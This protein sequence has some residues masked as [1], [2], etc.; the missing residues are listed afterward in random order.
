VRPRRRR[1]VRITLYTRS[2]CGLC[3]QAEALVAREAGGAEV[4]LVD[5]DVD[6]DLVRRYG[7]RVPVLVL[8]GTEVA[9]YELRRG[10]V[11]RLVRAARRRA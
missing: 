8:D 4:D 6:D 9:A 5:V 1:P 11:R 7:V 3:R 10:Q 2:G